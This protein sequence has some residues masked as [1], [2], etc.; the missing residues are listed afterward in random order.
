M[1]RKAADDLRVAV[2]DAVFKAERIV[3]DVLPGSLGGRDKPKTGGG[4]KKSTEDV[5]NWIDA[6]EDLGSEVEGYVSLFTGETMSVVDR[7]QEQFSA[8]QTAEIL[9]R[10]RAIEEAAE[11]QKKWAAEMVDLVAKAESASAELA[12]LQKEIISEMAAPMDELSSAMK[13]VVATGFDDA[14]RSAL[15]FENN[16]KQIAQNLLREIAVLI[17][18]MLLLKAIQAGF[19]ATAGTSLGSGMGG[20]LGGLITGNFGGGMAGGGTYIAGG[21]GGVDSRNV[22]FRVTPGER[23]TFTPP[24][25]MAPAN[26]N[27]GGGAAPVSVPLSIHLGGDLNALVTKH[28]SSPE[29]E[30]IVIDIVAK[31]AG[32]LRGALAR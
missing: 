11:A 32:K 6:F 10:N 22:M 19:G 18:K 28:L 29:G 15:N 25:Q 17:A 3:G 31:H 27:T 12:A 7:F 14:L 21:S 4:T 30:Q 16:F 13:D 2:R 9:E 23:I 24:G 20:F 5:Y 1:D 26:S 8:E